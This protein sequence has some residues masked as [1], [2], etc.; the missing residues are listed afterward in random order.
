MSKRNLLNLVLLIFI[1]LLVVLVIYEP[2]KKKAVTPPTLT[3]L[4]ENEVQHITITRKNGTQTIELIKKNGSWKMLQPYQQAANTF[5]IEAILKLLS[6]VSFSQNNLT[7]LNPAEFGLNK[8]V[9]TITFNKKTQIIFGNNKSLNHHR[10]VQIGSILHMTGDI[11]YY[12]L[13][14]NPESFINH[15]LLPENSKIT[16]LTL[17]ELKVS[18][19]DGKWTAATKEK[20]YS[21]DSINQLID[22][23]QLSQAYDV[24]IKKFSK[25]SKADIKIKFKNHAVINFIIEK[26]KDSFSLTNINNGVNY[27]L[28]ADRKDKLLKLSPLEDN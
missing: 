21:A 17:P 14:A 23:W 11:F 6:A 26:E 15:K 2:G 27:I 7:N 13:A 1:S 19:I 8:P 22:E 9:A 12:K 5:R 16:E 4:K 10:Y 20:K 28:S 3:N 24:K 25:N 18:Q